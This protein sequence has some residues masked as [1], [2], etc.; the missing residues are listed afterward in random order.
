MATDAR[1]STALPQHP[2]CKKLLRRLGPAGAWAL[3]CLIV[4]TSANR[5]NG[6]LGGMTDED[7]ELAV[8]WSGE[9]GA[10]VTALSEIGF[11]DGAPMARALH[12]WEEHNPFAASS[13]ERSDSARWAALCKRYGRDG[14]AAR[15]PDYA[16]RMR[17]AS[18][19]DAGRTNPQCGAD[20]PSPSPSP[21]PT[22]SPKPKPTPIPGEGAAVT[23][24]PTRTRDTSPQVARPDDVTVQ[25]WNDWVALRTKKKSA[26]SGTAINGARK[27]AAIA[28]VSLEAF[29]QEWCL[30]GSQ[31]MKGAWMLEDA[32]Q[33][34]RPPGRT[35]PMTDALRAATVAANTERAKRM[36]LGD[37]PDGDVFELETTGISHE[38][39]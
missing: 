15:M 23:A 37:G 39:K 19:P 18:E 38:E 13:G 21:I 3:V 12:D 30:R 26:V 25:T 34:H 11:L 32:T 5:P 31:G 14:A 1:I 29:L 6:D 17:P 16:K 27:E 35:P 4:W 24:I 2:K 20:A 7:I 8:D 28:G 10:L 9:D 36:L 22:P 33:H